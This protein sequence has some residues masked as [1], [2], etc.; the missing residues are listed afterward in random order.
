MGRLARQTMPLDLTIEAGADAVR[1]AAVERVRRDGPRPD[2]ARVGASGV[3]A[4]D[5]AFVVPAVDVP[6]TPAPLDTPGA[7][8]PVTFVGAGDIGDGGLAGAGLT[9]RAVQGIP[10]SVL[11][12]LAITCT[13]WPPARRSTR[14]TSPRGARSGTGRI[15][16]PAITSGRESRRTLSDVFRRGGGPR[17]LQPRSRERGTALAQQQRR[18]AP[19]FAKVPSGSAPTC[20]TRGPTLH[21]RLLASPAVQLRPERPQP[22]D[23]GGVGA[24]RQ[25]RRGRS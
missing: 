19:G 3:D 17:F 14:A 4:N 20:A 21:A 15:P 22:A 9:A 2:A 16:R 1:G 10:G 24:A 12:R 7:M 8:S 11:R 23:A 6:V 25:G 13:R 5:R 18:R